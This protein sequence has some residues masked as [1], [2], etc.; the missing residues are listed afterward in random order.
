MTHGR[1]SFRRQFRGYEEMPSEAAQR[2]VDE[3]SKAQAEAVA[4]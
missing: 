1:A 3:A 2:V 4:H